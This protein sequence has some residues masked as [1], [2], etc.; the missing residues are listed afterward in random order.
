MGL[1]I[2]VALNHAPTLPPS[3][4]TTATQAQQNAL[5]NQTQTKVLNVAQNGVFKNRLVEIS[6][7]QQIVKLV[8]KLLLQE[9]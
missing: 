5:Q 7:Y 4:K 9:H 1:S 2:T 3:A 8:H 6:H